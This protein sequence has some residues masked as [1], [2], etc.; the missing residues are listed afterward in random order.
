GLPKQTTHSSNDLLDLVV[1]V[2]HPH[3]PLYGQKVTVIRIRH[4]PDPDLIIRCPDGFHGAISAS[5]TDYSFNP[6]FELM[7]DPPPLLDIAGLFEMV[8]FIGQICQQQLSDN[9]QIG[10]DNQS[11]YAQSNKS[12]SASK[13]SGGE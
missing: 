3:H 7:P 5:W 4:F 9:S 8:K 2:T 13:S 11:Q 6:E 1:T 12:D 10:S